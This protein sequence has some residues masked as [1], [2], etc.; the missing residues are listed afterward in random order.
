[1]TKNTRTFLLGA[2]LAARTAVAAIAVASGTLLFGPLWLITRMGLRELVTTHRESIGLGCLA[3]TATLLVTQVFPWGIRVVLGHLKEWSDFR[4]GKK[5]L[6]DLTRSEKNILN[7]YVSRDTSTLVLD[8]KSGAT[9]ALQRDGIIC[10][11]SEL[12]NTSEETSI[13]LIFTIVPWAWNYLRTNRRVL[14]GP[15]TSPTRL[16]DW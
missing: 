16:S 14:E 10:R 12:E 4:K 7:Q 11:T 3:S 9:M 6:H 1:M 2:R 5:R 8:G 15:E 13:G